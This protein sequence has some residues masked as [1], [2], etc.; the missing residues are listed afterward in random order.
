[1][2]TNPTEEKPTTKSIAA[3]V[4]SN[5][6]RARK[7]QRTL[8]VQQQDDAGIQSTQVTQDVQGVQGIQGI[9][10]RGAGAGSDGF[11]QEADRVSAAVVDGRPLLR[12]AGNLVL[13]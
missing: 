12:S 7:A 9:H 5:A 4:K 10:C 3:Y 11:E 2:A 6:A 13:G 1:M 8:D